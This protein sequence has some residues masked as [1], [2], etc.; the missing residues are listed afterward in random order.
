MSPWAD[1]DKAVEEIGDE[2]YVLS[3]KPNPA[4]LAYDVWNPELARKNVHEIL[5]KTK[6]H[7][8][9]IILADISTVR[10]EPQ[11]VWEWTEIAREEA[12]KFA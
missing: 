6:G 12:E 8:V 1:I 11:R 10:Y 5:K 7:A 2:D 3:C 4:V 9:E